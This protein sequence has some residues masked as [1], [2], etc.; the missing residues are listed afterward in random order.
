MYSST[1]VAILAQFVDIMAD[2]DADGVLI[3]GGAAHNGDDGDEDDDGVLCA[4]PP[5]LP[6]VGRMGRPREPDRSGVFGAWLFSETPVV[7]ARVVAARSAGVFPGAG[8]TLERQIVALGRLRWE[9]SWCAE[10]EH[11]LLPKL[12]I[13]YELVECWTLAAPFLLPDHIDTSDLLV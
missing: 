3:A 1:S 12:Q 2:D 5:D 11:G 4:G 8:A 6:D 10:P 7:G 9:V 13:L